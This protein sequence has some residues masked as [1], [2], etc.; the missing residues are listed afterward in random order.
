MSNKRIF[1]FAVLCLLV[2]SNTAFAQYNWWERKIMWNGTVSNDWHDPNNWVFDPCDVGWGGNPLPPIS[3]PNETHW[4]CLQGNPDVNLS[5]PAPIAVARTSVAC[6]PAGQSTITF[7]IDAN[8]TTFEAGWYFDIAV[9]EDNGVYGIVNMYG[10]QITTSITDAW[11]NPAQGVWIGGGSSRTGDSYGILNMYGGSITVPKIDLVR[12]TINLYGGLLDDTATGL[13]FPVSENGKVNIAGGTLKAKG[14]KTPASSWLSKGIADGRFVA[15]DDRGDFVIDYNLTEVYTYVTAE[16]NYGRAWDPQPANRSEGVGAQPTL[17]WRPGDWVADVNGHDVYLGT[18]A[19]EVADANTNSSCYLGTV[20]AN[21]YPITSNLDVSTMYYWRVDEVNEAN[22]DSPWKGQPW[23]FE[24]VHGRSTSPSPE[25]GAVGLRIEEVELTWAAG[26]WAAVTQGHDV[27]FGTNPAEVNSIQPGDPDPNNVHKGLQ[28]TTSYSP[29]VLYYDVNYHWRV[30]EVNNAH[31]D[32]RWKGD[33]WDFNMTD[34]Y[35]VDQFQEYEDTNDMLTRWLTDTLEPGCGWGWGGGATLELSGGEMAY[36]YDNNSAPWGSDLYSEARF[37]YGPSG[38]DWSGG[39]VPSETPMILYMAFTGNV[40]NSADPNYDRMYVA[41]E[42]TAGDFWMILHEDPNVQRR[43]MQ[44]EWLIDLGEF[45]SGNDVNLD[46]VRYLYIGFGERC[47]PPIGTMGEEGD[48]TF[49]NIRLYPPRCVPQYGPEADFTSDCFV[50]YA[51]VGVVARD[52]LEKEG[53][54]TFDVVNEPCSPVLWYKFDETSGT[55]A[56]DSAG[57][58]NGTVENLGEATWATTSGYD[59]NGCINL[60]A[61]DNTYVDVP[62]DALNFLSSATGVTF[63]VWVNMDLGNPPSGSWPMVFNAWKGGTEVI[64]TYCPSPYPRPAEDIYDPELHWHMAPDY[65][66]TVGFTP[67]DFGGRWNHVAFVKDT[68]ANT[69]STYH[70]GQLAGHFTD[71]NSPFFTP[72][73]DTFHIGTRDPTWGFWYGRID[74]VRVYDYAL[75]AEEIAYIATDGT[76]SIF[77]PMG[78]VAN[79]Y[80][81]SPEIIDFKDYAEMASQWLERK[82]WPIP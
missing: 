64:E 34:Y 8:V 4:V 67:S 23:K 76:G 9:F 49:H 54:R 5:G 27:F 6:W 40:N 48:V 1:I 65:T 33:L 63:T 20:H 16:P 17:T 53:L 80:S 30:D 52:W 35:S 3:E 81:S 62:T 32:L 57:D 7:D 41:L 25:S 82:H 61:G 79:L 39:G 47:N 60:Q 14:N 46:A 21:S 15:Y 69:M 10:G 68:D 66:T 56:T 70:N 18:D 55:T 45:S 31:P 28:D 51:D 26:P 13:S 58:H 73:P 2:V 12:G 77:I 72:P 74:D 29:A 19:T 59:S 37:E 36:H 11:G 78:S 24:T 38:A 44:Q 22:G 42:D 43:D 75:S 71:M 50:D